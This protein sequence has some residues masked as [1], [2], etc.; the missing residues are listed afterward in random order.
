VYSSISVRIFSLRPSCVSDKI[1]APD[2]VGACGP[3]P[4]ALTVVKPQT[5]PR[6]LLLRYFQPFPPPDPLH[7]ILAHRPAGLIQQRRDPAIAVAPVLTRQ[8]DKRRGQ[9]VFGDTPQR[10]TAPGAPPL[11]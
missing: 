4:Y 10:C 8:S 6:T 3:E 5:P 7:P 2:V 1:V 11:L 9:R